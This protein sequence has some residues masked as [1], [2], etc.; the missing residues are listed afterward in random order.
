MERNLNELAELE[1]FDNGKAVDASK[2]V[3]LPDSISCLRYYAGWAD[4]IVGQV[5]R[6]LLVLMTH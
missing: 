2:T 3:D 5:G 4:K 1:A 6:V